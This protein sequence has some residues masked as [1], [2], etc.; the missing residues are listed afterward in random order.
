MSVRDNDKLRFKVTGLTD[1]ITVAGFE[2]NSNQGEERATQLESDL[3][4]NVDI[5]LTNNRH[6]IFEAI[7]TQGSD[8]EKFLIRETNLKTVVAVEYEDAR[9]KN[10]ITYISNEAVI[11][12]HPDRGGGKGNNQITYTI[13]AND[14]TVKV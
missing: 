2:L 10:K 3:Y 8:E 14:V 6:R 4:G 1:S 9:G 11:A 5:D 13:L 12:G 7:V